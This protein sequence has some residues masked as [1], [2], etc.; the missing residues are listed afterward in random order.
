[1]TPK[2]RIAVPLA[3]FLYCTTEKISHFRIA[4]SV[5]RPNEISNQVS[6]SNVRFR[7]QT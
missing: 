6:Y 4:A 3:R 1:M 7:I 5:K 2:T